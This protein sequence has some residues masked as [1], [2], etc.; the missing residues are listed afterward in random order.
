MNEQMLNTQSDSEDL[1]LEALNHYDY[2]ESLSDISEVNEHLLIALQ[3]LNMRDDLEPEVK[4]DLTN[5]YIKHAIGHK[6]ELILSK[7]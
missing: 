4:V 3:F 2:I 5:K 1:V 6:N 7:N